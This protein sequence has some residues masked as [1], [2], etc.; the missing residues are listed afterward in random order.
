MKKRALNAFTILYVSFSI[1]VAHCSLVEI[2]ASPTHSLTKGGFLVSSAPV[3][4]HSKRLY[5]SDAGTNRGPQDC[6]DCQV[7]K[8]RVEV[9]T[10]TWCG[11]CKQWKQKELPD[12]LKAGVKVV[13][14]DIDK[15]DEPDSVRYVPTMR[16]YYK[17]KFVKQQTYWK[18][19]DILAFIAR[20]NVTKDRVLNA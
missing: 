7:C 16:L 14:R 2:E 8:Y 20:H 15:E 13:V 10:A 17:G 19:K 12:L 6:N 18:A 5:Q 3:L 9:W 11:P 4:Q 1:L